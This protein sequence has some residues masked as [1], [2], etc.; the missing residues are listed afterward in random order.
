[1]R[2][3][4]PDPDRN[5]SLAMRD[6]N[7]KAKYNR[8]MRKL[9]EDR[10][11]KNFGFMKVSYASKD[12]VI[13]R[14]VSTLSGYVQNKHAKNPLVDALLKLTGSLADNVVQRKIGTKKLLAADEQYTEVLDIHKDAN[15]MAK[16]S[17]IKNNNNQEIINNTR[18]SNFWVKPEDAVAE[19]FINYFQSHT[20]DTGSQENSSNLIK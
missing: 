17:I 2:I 12:D 15:K 5:R 3:L 16:N 20:I 11:Y 13:S 4:P 18:V 7:A 9:D 10:H 8:E 6:L 19:H 14:T 1:M